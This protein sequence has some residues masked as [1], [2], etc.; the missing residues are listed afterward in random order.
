MDGSAPS[1]A[2]ADGPTMTT[3]EVARLFHVAPGTV[4]TWD[5]WLKD[6]ISRTLGGHRRYHAYKVLAVH[7][8]LRVTEPPSAETPGPASVVAD[9][10]TGPGSTPHTS[11]PDGTPRQVP[12]PSGPAQA[13]VS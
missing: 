1:P 10:R 4:R 5:G 3:G 6:A 12:L 9:M 11:G 7:A 13:G 8:A 2:L